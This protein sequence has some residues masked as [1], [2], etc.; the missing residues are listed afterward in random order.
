VLG[1]LVA[2]RTNA[3]AVSAVAVFVLVLAGSVGETGATDLWS[4]MV[5]KSTPQSQFQLFES[6]AQSGLNYRTRAGLPLPAGGG[7]TI[8]A[9]SGS[10]GKGCGIDFAGE[11]KALFDANALDRFIHERART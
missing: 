3:V 2:A 1:P 7:G 5:T 4:Q 8:G 10:T 6:T 11:F 9:I